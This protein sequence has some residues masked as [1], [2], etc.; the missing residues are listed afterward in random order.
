MIAELVASADRL[1]YIAYSQYRDQKRREWKLVSVDFEKSIRQYASCLQDGRFLVEF[2]IEHHR[3]SNLDICSRRYWLE[4]HRTNAHDTLSSDYHILQPSEYS[5][6]IAKS[7]VRERCEE[8]V[9]NL[10]FSD[11]TLRDLT[12]LERQNNVLDNLTFLV[13]ILFYFISSIQLVHFIAMSYKCFPLRIFWEIP[14][15]S[16]V[17]FYLEIPCRNFS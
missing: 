2:F 15:Q 11:T 8:F 16:M 12:E 6:A 1:F 3:D 5:P 9:F 7:E 13:F 4:Y 17:G 10:Q 14:F